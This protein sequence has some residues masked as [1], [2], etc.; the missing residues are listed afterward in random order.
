MGRAADEDGDF[1]VV[2]YAGKYREEAP[3]P[4]DAER[5]AADLRKR[6]VPARAYR[7]DP[8]EVRKLG[9]AQR[10]ILRTV[11]DFGEV[12]PTGTPY[13]RRCRIINAADKMRRRGF[14]VS[15]PHNHPDVIAGNG[16]YRLT[17]LGKT[18]LRALEGGLCAA[19]E[20]R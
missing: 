11:Q 19:K 12:V 15:L 4:A 16:Q 8:G 6:D 18:A 13:E 3:S 7:Y 20:R 14:L 17:R 5:A 10:A 1:W 2:E 9:E